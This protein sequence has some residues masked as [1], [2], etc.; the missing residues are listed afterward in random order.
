MPISTEKE[1]VIKYRKLNRSE[2]KEVHRFIKLISYLRPDK[3]FTVDKTLI[4]YKTGSLTQ[5][6]IDTITDEI[7]KLFK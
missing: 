1:I 7:V 3:I 4:L 5:S 2:K 6:K